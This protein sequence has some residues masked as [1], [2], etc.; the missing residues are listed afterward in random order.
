[1]ARFLVAALV[2]SLLIFA[3]GGVWSYPCRRYAAHHSL[4]LFRL[5]G[6]RRR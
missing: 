5:A 3:G 1:M 6:G 2:L 4:G